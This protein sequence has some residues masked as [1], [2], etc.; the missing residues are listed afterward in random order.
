[1][2]INE[3]MIIECGDQRCRLPAPL[4]SVTATRSFHIHGVGCAQ[5]IVDRRE[6]GIMVPMSTRSDLLVR[7]I[8]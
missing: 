5:A 3:I 2:L 4:F 8:Q 7:Q 6:R 1:M